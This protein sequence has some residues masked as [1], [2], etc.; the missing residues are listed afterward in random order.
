MMSHPLF[1]ASQQNSSG[2]KPELVKVNLKL[3]VAVA[4][5]STSTFPFTL[6][7]QRCK[8]RDGETGVSHLFQSINVLIRRFY[9]WTAG[10]T[11]TEATWQLW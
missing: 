1:L 3:A 7:L 4:S 6:G 2:F 5:T 9:K 11:T 8:N 10:D